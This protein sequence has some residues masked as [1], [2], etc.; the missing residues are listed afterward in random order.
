MF[1]NYITWS[2]SFHPIRTVS[3]QSDGINV[4]TSQCFGFKFIGLFIS[5]YNLRLVTHRSID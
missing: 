3:D 1:T 4:V 2:Q 5:M